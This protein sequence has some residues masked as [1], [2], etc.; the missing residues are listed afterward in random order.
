ML[1]WAVRRKDKLWVP[2]L[3]SPAFWPVRTRGQKLSFTRSCSR[4]DS[5]QITSSSSVIFSLTASLVSVSCAGCVG[6]LA[7]A[8]LFSALTLSNQ[9]WHTEGSDDSREDKVT[10]S[11]T[12]NEGYAQ[13][14]LTGPHRAWAHSYALNTHCAHACVSAHTQAF[15]SV[16]SRK[17]EQECFADGAFF[18]LV[19]VQSQKQLPIKISSFP[20]QNV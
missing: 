17:A 6:T 13:L 7:G 12:F 20:S 2:T 9:M 16:R 3:T 19:P 4:S 18:S 11:P 1:Q 8:L 5:S 10:Q 14:L 15:A